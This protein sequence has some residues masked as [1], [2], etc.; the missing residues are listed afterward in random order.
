MPNWLHRQFSIETPRH[1]KEGMVLLANITIIIVR[2]SGSLVV[3]AALHHLIY[4]PV[5][6]RGLV[7]ED[8]CTKTITTSV[9]VKVDATTQTRPNIPISQRQRFH[10]PVTPLNLVYSKVARNNSALDDLELHVQIRPRNVKKANISVFD[11]QNPLNP[12]VN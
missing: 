6:V 7:V 4:G 5:P 1:K 10:P 8:H 12:I 3:K 11:V 2:G 9:L